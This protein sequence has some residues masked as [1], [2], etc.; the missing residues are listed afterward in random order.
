MCKNTEKGRISIQFNS[1]TIN[2]SYKDSFYVELK[3]LLSHC[4][5]R[6][7]TEE[8]SDDPS[9]AEPKKK[10]GR[11]S[12]NVQLRVISLTWCCSQ[13]CSDSPALE[14]I[15]GNE[16][17]QFNI[18]LLFIP[19]LNPMEGNAVFLRCVR[20]TDPEPVGGA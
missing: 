20:T 19:C 8:G 3:C 13:V 10:E 9:P 2:T 6:V 17:D 11:L 1:K 5:G 15:H 12:G 18:V 14:T 7:Q 4:N 16:R